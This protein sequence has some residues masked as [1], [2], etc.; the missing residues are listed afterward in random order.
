VTSSAADDRW[1]RL[2]WL[3]VLAALVV[4]LAF[5]FGYWRNKP[6]TNDEQEYLLLAG[7]LAAGHGYDYPDT[8]EGGSV[9]RFGRAP[10]YPVFLAPLVGTA[11]LPP[12]VPAEVKLAQCVV[13]AFGTLLIGLLAR[14]V[15]GTLAGI[16]AAFLSAIYPPLVWLSGY[17]LSEVLFVPFIIGATLL[18]I[19]LT[20]PPADGA[21]DNW[22]RG[23]LVGLLL[24]VSALVR[25]SALGFL[26]LAVVWVVVRRRKMAAVAILAGAVAVIAPWSARNV[27]HYGRFVMIASEGGV[28]FW[29]GNHRLSAGEGDM[30]A[31]PAIKR[32]YLEIVRAHP[33]ASQETLEPIFYREAFK[34]IAASPGWW[35]TLLARK[36]FY[37]WVPIGRS[38]TLH[39]RLHYAVTLGSYLLL[40]PVA[41]AGLVILARRDAQPWALWLLGLSAVILS[42]LLISTERYRI[43]V[44]DPVLIICAGAWLA[45]RG[46]QLQPP[47]RS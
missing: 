17:A 18:A 34:T 16:W 19:P 30:A 37:L 32:D 8:P 44:I 22:K 42:V 1:T 21:S 43:P 35:M 41:L 9:R 12:S 36:F 20:D 25:P 10:G 28:T 6:M 23:L 27:A 46:G 3:A 13:G 45:S 38:Y 7:S 15:A 4:R 24:G 11:P 26:G 2:V 33:G 31:N 40:L 47:T 5:A 29:T 14:R 39:S